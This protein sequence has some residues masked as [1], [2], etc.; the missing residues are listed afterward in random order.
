M[1]RP[2]YIKREQRIKTNNNNKNQQTGKYTVLLL[3]RKIS[4][5]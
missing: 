1:N 5:I 3:T 2:Y 4:A